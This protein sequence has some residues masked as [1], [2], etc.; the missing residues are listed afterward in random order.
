MGTTA[1]IIMHTMGIYVRKERRA[2]DRI[3][4]WLVTSYRKDGKVHQK[5][6]MYFGNKEPVLEEVESAKLLFSS[7]IEELKKP[8]LNNDK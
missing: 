7:K 6:L 1:Q 2:N 5:K 4:Y 3:Y 8:K